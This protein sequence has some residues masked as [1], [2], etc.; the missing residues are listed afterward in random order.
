MKF[1]FKMSTW[2]TLLT[3]HMSKYVDSTNKE[4]SVMYSPNLNETPA[5]NPSTISYC[6]SPQELLSSNRIETSEFGDCSTKKLKY[7]E[8][9]DKIQ[10]EILALKKKNESFNGHTP[11]ISQK[12]ENFSK[13]KK[14]DISNEKINSNEKYFVQISE[15][16]NHFIKQTNQKSRQSLFF[17]FYYFLKHYKIVR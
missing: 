8:K 9:L 17:H 13:Q 6:K 2:R 7:Q 3:P 5:N 12:D 16:K 10:K 1:N 15:R 14:S 4:N 11:S